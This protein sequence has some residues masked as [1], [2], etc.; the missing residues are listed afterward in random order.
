MDARGTDVWT[1]LGGVPVMKAESSRHVILWGTTGLI[2][3]EIP[4]LERAP[5]NMVFWL[6]RQRFDIAAFDVA[7]SAMREMTRVDCAHLH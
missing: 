2:V 5:S 7:E 6:L 1:R 3:D 4:C